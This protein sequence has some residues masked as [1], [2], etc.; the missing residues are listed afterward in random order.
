[1]V[2]VT[3][4]PIRRREDD[5]LGRVSLARKFSEHLLSLDASEGVVV[6]VLGP[7]GSGKT[8]F[9]NLV[10]L[11][12]A[13]AGVTVIDFN[14]WMFSGVEQLVHS[15]FTELV[16]QLRLRPDLS[17]VAQAIEEYGEIFSGVTQLLGLGKWSLWIGLLRAVAGVQRK[18][19]QGI[20]R[21]RARVES[22]LGT[23]ER[24]I[25]VILD[26]I[27]RLSAAEIR[28]I[29]KLVR[30][31]A[32]FPN[33]IYILAFDRTRVEKALEEQGIAGRDY[34]EK[35]LQVGFDLPTVPQRVLEGQIITAIEAALSGIENPGPFDAQAWP[36]IFA[37][38]IRP[39][40]RNMRDVRR[41]AAA[42]HGTIKGLDGQIALADVLAL[43]AVRLFL[44]DVFA[45][46]C[47]SVD[48]L[49]TP[50]GIFYGVRDDERHLK[51]SIEALI[52]KG[53][54]NGNKETV[55][56]IIRRLFPA[57]LRHVGGY[58]YGPEWTKRWLRNRRVAHK[59]ILTLY[60]ENVVGES[61]QSF[62]DAE[63]AWGVLADKDALEKYLR[64]LDPEQL[65]DVI[66]SLEVFEDQFSEEHVIP[67]T[68]V[69]LNLLPDI[70][71]RPRGMVGL[72]V[73]TTVGRVVLRLLR[74]L[75]D[76]SAVEE[77]VKAIIPKLTTLSAKLLLITIVGHREGAGHQL[78]SK[79]AAAEFERNWRC[80]VRSANAAVLTREPD[81]MR[82]LLT[83][84]REAEASEPELNI[85]DDP[86]L[87]LAILRS[88]QTEVLSFS[89]GS[90]A[91]RRSPRLAW[92]ALVE[93]FGDE[94]T[95]KNRVSRLKDSG[96]PVEAELLGLVEK[97]LEGWRPGDIDQE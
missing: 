92:D 76:P 49:T 10:R 66:Q 39:L 62:L 46:L 95:L 1:M 44:P 86:S 26:D 87:T 2:V 81:L 63:R 85:P 57:A 41:Y 19:E 24:P 56:S 35:I 78:V 80:E 7:W 55:L 67:G 33:I 94:E 31:V 52:Q 37:E 43:E 4:N 27:D 30:L 25:V 21:L 72:D 9:L 71:H 8:S 15:F 36:D 70:P 34:L 88:A 65:E 97:Y 61:L 79:E 14:P 96:L 64:S 42:I 50:S 3:D 60:L 13:D 73:R 77:A 18:R 32:R 29:F 12:L 53:E 45:L 11:E 83:A 20:D 74:S 69:L 47:K 40:I 82:V 6:G 48:A 75:K 68:I 38:V 5:V 91:V 84:K 58:H 22:A 51:A 54:A 28:D 59:D 16:V 90:R 93:L 89:M 17:E 23:L